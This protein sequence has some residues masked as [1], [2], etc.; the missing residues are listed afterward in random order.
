M[1]SI[2]LGL[3]LNQFPSGSN[4][5]RHYLWC[6]AQ[7]AS[8]QPSFSWSCWELEP[9]RQ[10]SSLVH[11][12][13]SSSGS[14]RTFYCYEHIRSNIHYWTYCW[15]GSHMTRLTVLSLG[16]LLQWSWRCGD[17]T[18]PSDRQTRVI[19][20]LDWQDTDPIKR[21]PQSYQTSLGSLGRADFL[22]VM[23]FWKVLRRR[24]VITS[25]LLQVSVGR[26]LGNC[27]RSNIKNRREH[28]ECI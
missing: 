16:L 20:S 4:S 9:E 21:W 18:I 14:S 19:T 1:I 27:I 28:S 11:F 6:V 10:I 26:K 3:R 8:T 5:A 7:S 12:V 15:A 17:S 24:T 22:F 13:L 25:S 2:K 23:I